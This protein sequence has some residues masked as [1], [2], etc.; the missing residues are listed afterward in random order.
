MKRTT[1]YIIFSVIVFFNSAAGALAEG[2]SKV[3]SLQVSGMIS[4]TCP[5]LLKSAVRRLKG[6]KNVSA[7][8]ENKSATIEFDEKQ[9]SLEKIQDTIEEQVGFSTK[10]Q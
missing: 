9:V 2:K 5:V 1:L 6:V 7:S 4:K 3:V 8:L 10:L